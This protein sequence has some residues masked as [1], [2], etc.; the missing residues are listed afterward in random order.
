MASILNKLLGGVLA[1]PVLVINFDYERADVKYHDVL[2]RGLNCEFAQ[3]EDVAFV[4]GEVEVKDR[5]L[6]EYSFVLFGTVGERDAVH[7]SAMECA[8][9]C[10]V[11]HFT[12]GQSEERCS[13]ILQT[14]RFARDS[15]A[16]PKTVILTAHPDRAD[17]LIK[18]LKLPI[19]TKIVDGSQGKGI[20][21]HDTKEGLTKALKKHAGEQL[22]VQEA[23]TTSCD[24]RIMFIYDEP[25]Y[26]M[27]R[28]ATTKGEFRHNV[29]LG[30]KFE[31]IKKPTTE[32]LVLAKQAQKAMGYDISGVDVIQDDETKQWYVLEVNA[33]PQF[34]MPK[35]VVEKLVDII[36]GRIG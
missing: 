1:K 30:G 14:V 11:P 36:K 2:K 9:K 26:V 33:A 25:I 7:A 3:W 4:N 32:M 12:Y 21:K 22:I 34:I 5:K 27:K 10:G 28:S 15:V 24:Y 17:S 6:S 19:V 13:K 8:D 23:L 18:E 31:V 35:S 16:H 20:E 29:S